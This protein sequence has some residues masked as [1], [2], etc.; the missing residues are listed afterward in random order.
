LSLANWTDLDLSFGAIQALVPRGDAITVIQENKASQI[1]VGRNLI[2]Y[3]GGDANVTVSKNVLGIPSYYAGDYGTENPESVVERFGVVYYADVKRGK[4]VRLSADGITPISEKGLDS[5]FEDAFKGV[6]SS[7]AS[8]MVIGG[9]DPDNDEYLITVEP[10]YISSVT[11][12]SNTYEV[13]VDDNDNV[14]ADTIT[15]TSSTIIWNA[16]GNLWNTYCG[17]WED[18]G[19]GVIFIDSLSLPQSVLVDSIYTG[20]GA[21]I[22][23]IITDSNYSFSATA[24][25]NLSNGIITFPSTTCEGTTITIGTSQ[26]DNIGFTIGYK[27]KE[28]VWGSKYS[29]TPTS[30][31]NINNE[32]YS[33]LD[34]SAGLMWKHNSNETR[35][36]FY[37][38]QYSSMFEVVSNMNP[39][40]VKVYE[41][42]GVEG[43]GTWSAVLSNT[44]QSTT[45]STSD[46]DNREGHRYAMIPR[47]TLVSTGHQIYLGRV[48]AVSA[49]TV[50]FTT[51]VNRLPFVVG[52]DLYTASGSTLTDTT[53]NIAGIT[54]RK[55][56]QY[57]CS[58]WNICR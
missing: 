52:D 7:T 21:T 9:F 31:V 24:Q 13:S 38:T 46:F 26:Q 15:Y 56:I 36:N 55:T 58:V 27:H 18:A 16:V 57:F 5:F 8:N 17:N 11:I 2:E 12:G 51:P 29:F 6:L 14:I 42:L 35:N 45:I 1:P 3:S 41:A 49:D 19:N 10:N 54:N 53:M 43:D 48:E 39:S 37:G 28:G 30:Y 50:T 23:I 44:D 25:L 20:S 32:L 22:D 34:A 47:D 33:F 4:V 40:M